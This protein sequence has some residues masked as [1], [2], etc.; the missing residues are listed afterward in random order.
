V[1]LDGWHDRPV[2][3]QP[4]DDERAGAVLS[5]HYLAG[6]PTALVAAGVIVLI[7]RWV[8]SPPKPAAAVSPAVS[9]A[10]PP[11]AAPEDFGL[12]VPVARAGTAEEAERLAQRVRAAGIRCTV[13]DGGEDLLLLVFRSDAER[14]SGLVDR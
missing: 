6:L 10:V 11:R 4:P 14:A 3:V 9:P 1:P 13:T 5:Y 8:F 2:P 7:C 12:L